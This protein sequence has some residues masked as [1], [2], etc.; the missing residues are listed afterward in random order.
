MKKYLIFIACAAT[1]WFTPTNTSAQNITTIA[2]TGVAGFSGDGGAATAGRIYDPHDMCMDGGGNIYFADWSNNRVRK[3][4]ASGIITTIAGTGGFGFA[5]DGGPA[6][7]ALLNRPYGITVDHSGNVYFS[8]EFN[9]RIRKISAAGTISTVAGTGITGY[10]GDGG[11][12]TAAQIWVPL[13]MGVDVA[14][15]I[16]F[17]DNQ[18]HR[19]RKVTPAG[20]ISTVAGS[21]LAGY[22]GDGGPATAARLNFPGDMVFDPAGNMYFCDG[23]NHCVRKVNPSGIIST[24]AGIGLAGFTGDGGP[25]TAARLNEAQCVA[26]DNAGNIYVSDYQNNRIR[27]INTSGIISTVVGTG[28]PLYN[29][30]GIPATTANIDHPVGVWVDAANTLYLADQYNQRIRKLGPN[31]PTFTAGAVGS[32]AL[33]VDES[34]TPINSLLAVSDLDAGQTLTWSI[35]TAPSHGTLVA[36]YSA[37]STGGVVTPTGT[38]YMPVAGYT[39][40]D[41]F[42]VQVYDGTAYDTI[43]INV[44]VSSLPGA[45]VI[46]G[47]GSVCVGSSVTLTASAGGGVWSYVTGA[48]I[49]SSGVV[50]GL[51][52]GIDTA[53]YTVTN[54]CGSATAKKPVTVLPLPDAGVISGIDSVCV[55]NSITLS[56]TESGGIWSHYVTGVATVG[57]TGIV[58]GVAAGIDTIAYSVTNACGTASVIHRVKVLPLPNAG[59]ISGIDSVCPGAIITLSETATG[60]IWSHAVTGVTTIS[61][62]GIVSGM[63]TGIDTI[64]YTVT[65]SCGT[66]IAQY[67]V[68]V[69]SVNYCHSLAVEGVAASSDECTI[70]PNPSN[71]KFTVLVSSPVSKDVMVTITDIAGRRLQEF[72]V[73]TNVPAEFS[74]AMSPGVYFLNVVSGEG[75]ISKKIILTPQ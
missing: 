32:L 36:S 62:T 69:L 48:A 65:N 10:S 26:L 59:I 64:V 49:V 2:G 50:T 16:Y 70:Y 22:M 33:C 75:I 40:S 74:T 23:I 34:P 55:G 3:I 45:G 9:H 67:I 14:D 51:V 35:V 43:T 25:A 29:G 39:G 52:P 63:T 41:I 61:T 17:A 5:G 19:I 42:K 53:V 68:K 13:Y 54:T 56:E 47:A 37:S 57:G 8:D 28:L 60:G 4:S 24:I 71:G 21:G 66:A 30:D 18:N 11:M 31:F 15:N 27:K 38:T 58:T 7:A 1:A 46:S 12:A 72:I 20:I 6:T 73:N 44:S